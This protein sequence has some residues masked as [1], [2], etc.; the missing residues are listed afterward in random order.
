VTAIDFEARYVKLDGSVIAYDYLVL[1]V[2]GQTNFFGLSSVEQNAHQVKNIPCAVETRNHLLR[3][4]ELASHEADAE[5]RRA[6]LTFV[7]V[8]G[9][10]TGVE[11]AGALAEL[12]RLVMTKDYPEMD[13]QEVQVLL[14]E[15][16]DHLMGTYPPRLQQATFDLLEG[17]GVEIRLSTRLTE[18]DGMTRS[19]GPRV[20]GRRN[21]WMDWG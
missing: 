2:G 14:L 16:V 17:K 10:P 4:F 5:K 19:S 21:W 9:G 20:C 11:T 8:G 12:I 1:A 15:A 18:F 7:V 13:L 6:R 3:M